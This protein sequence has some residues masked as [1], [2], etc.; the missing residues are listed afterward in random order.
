[1]NTRHT[2]DPALDPAAHASTARENPV[3]TPTATDTAKEQKKKTRSARTTQGH[4][5]VLSQELVDFARKTEDRIS[6]K[7]G[8]FVAAHKMR[9]VDVYHTFSPLISDPSKVTLMMQGVQKV[10]LPVL[11]ALHYHFGVDLNE[12]IAGDSHKP[13]LP[14]DVE[15]KILELADAIRQYQ[16]RN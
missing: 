15:Q 4:Q 9:N 12:F 13:N 8:S 2:K 7:F 16:N 11:V 14:P 6:R 1:M 10:P 3:Q 5:Q